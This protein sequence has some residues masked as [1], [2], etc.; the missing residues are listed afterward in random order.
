[1]SDEEQG[2]EKAY[3]ATQQRL[4]EARK[5]GDTPNSKDLAAVAA[6][7][8][9]LLALYIAGSQAT[10]ATG[11]ALAGLFSNA[12]TMAPRLLAVGVAGTS[13]HLSV[14]AVLGLGPL[15]LLPFLLVLLV[16]LAQRSMVFGFDKIMPK[17][18]RISPISGAKQKFGITGMVEF[19]KAATKLTIISIILA[20]Y[21]MSEMDNIVGSARVLPQAA[22]V[23]MAE[24]AFGLLVRIT[25]IVGVIAA[26]DFFWQRYD[27]ARKLRMTYQ[28]V[29]DEHK[30]SERDPQTKAQRQRRAQDIATNQM[31]HDVPKADVVIVNPTHFAVAL[32]WERGNVGAPVL[33]AKGVDAIAL[34]IRQVAEESGIPI[35]SDP[36]T[37]RAIEATVEIGREIEPDQY[38]A[39][40]AA[41]RFAEAMRRKAKE[42]GA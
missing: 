38:H 1:M 20:I 23:Q 7:V 14:D 27:H 39:V 4:D 40:A 8:G 10:K 17:L 21:L 33:V 13:L 37:A 9:L 18:S 12:D 31:M 19:L 24:I 41:I 15:F 30:Q 6:Y 26:A 5:K 2:G 34:R 29:K 42:R 25:I 36:P 3:E 28:E 11:N 35:H 16:I 22:P 32:R